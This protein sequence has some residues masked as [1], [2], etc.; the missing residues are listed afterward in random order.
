M[1]SRY[2]KKTAKIEIS[3]PKLSKDDRLNLA[4]TRY[5]LA[6][7]IIGLKWDPALSSIYTVFICIW[8]ML[9]PRFL[10]AN[11]HSSSYS[12]LFP[13]RVNNLLKIET[14]KY[15]RPVW[16]SSIDMSLNKKGKVISPPFLYRIYSNYFLIK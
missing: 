11:K 16:V 5:I 8:V 2:D 7:S 9:Y 3:R 12:Y 6:E 14:G 1:E 10:I 15:L 13:G 4:N